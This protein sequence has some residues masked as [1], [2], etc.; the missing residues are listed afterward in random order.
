M[1][2]FVRDTLAC[3]RHVGHAPMGDGP[4]DVLLASAESGDNGEHNVEGHVTLSP[5][6]ERRSNFEKLDQNP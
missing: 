3:V 5:V 1:R 2:Q 4:M 6:E